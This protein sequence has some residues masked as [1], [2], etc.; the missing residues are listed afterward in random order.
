MT[1]RLKLL[2]SAGALAFL[3]VHLHALPNSLA[4]F[5]SI[6]FALGVETFDVARH[7]PHPPGYPVFI[8]L[9]RL[10]TAAV[11]VARPGWGR[12]HVAAAGLAILSVTAG[13]AAVFFVALFWRAVGF[14]S[15]QAVT[16]ALFTAVSPLYWLTASRPLS[17][18]AGFA[19]TMAVL[20]WLAAAWV[21]WDPAGPVPRSWWWAAAAAGLVVGVRSQ[22]LWQTAPILAAMGLDLWRRGRRREAGALTA[23]AAAGC[24]CWFVPLVVD[25]GGLDAY[26]VALGSQGG[27]DFRGVEMLAT[28]PSRRL[29]AQA[30]EYT[31]VEPWLEPPLAW[32][33][34]GLATLGL[35]RLVRQRSFALRLVV[36]AFVPYLVFHLLFQEVET[37]RYALPLVVP[38]VGLAV[39]GLSA[40]G[41][42]VAAAITIAV[43][44]A[45]VAV[46]APP[47][48]RFAHHGVPIFQ[49]F[50]DMQTRR[51]AEPVEPAIATHHQVWWVVRRAFDWYRP[52]WDVGP[53]PFPGDREW[54]GLVDR[55]RSGSGGPVWFLADQTR[56][57][58]EAFDPRTTTRAGRY[59]Q[60][61]AIRRLAGG[62]RLDSLDWWIVA[63]PAWMLGRGWALNPELSGMT[64]EDLAE[65]HRMPA[66]A[67]LRRDAGLRRLLV[68]G[69][70]LP[71][72]EAPAAR[73]ILTIDG[74]LLDDW[75]VDVH[76][77][78]FTRWI[79][80]PDLAGG[81]GPYATLQVEVASADPARPVPGDGLVA[82]EQFDA[83]PAGALMYAYAEGWHEREVDPGTGRQW[84][85]S[86]G[87]STLEVRDWGGDLTLTMFGESPLRYFDVAPTVSV[88]AGDRELA[89]FT[90]SDDFTES[91][92]VPREAL[93]AAGGLLRLETDRTFAPADRGDNEDRRRLGLRLFR[94]D[95]VRREVR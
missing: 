38:V 65:P 57:D 2:I 83:A 51:P 76:A 86:S 19:L 8:A 45:S 32:I 34:L 17:D 90:P 33:V 22:S 20:A 39:A 3:L 88:R 59:E 77:A 47:L 49:A 9:A 54:L 72:A 18:T 42:R 36:L 92:L 13:A 15:T 6:N 16:A 43:I 71:G 28:S 44:A 93:A 70:Y 25:T 53:Q 4:D 5:D 91:V 7:Q 1:P 80:L 26:L 87:A 74:R 94:I 68:G 73:L 56:H 64:A 52:V 61:D 66:Q 40:F 63:T 48:E 41:T 14:S 31:F 67:F 82:L 29:L 84:R 27:D 23:A 95:L 37:V 21:R 78:W 12:D 85:W 35:V 79:D 24:L 69:R 58:L 30:L 46:A 10:T 50:R 55:W 81:D 89:R 60:D 62:K 11:R 75:T